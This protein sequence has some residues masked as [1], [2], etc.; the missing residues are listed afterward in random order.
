MFTIPVCLSWAR[1]L[2]GQSLQDL[3]PTHQSLDQ[4]LIKGMKT[5][6]KECIA[7]II[8]LYYT[9]SLEAPPVSKG[10]GGGGGG[11]SNAEVGNLHLKGRNALFQIYPL[12]YANK[13]GLLV[14]K[15]E[16][17]KIF[18]LMCIKTIL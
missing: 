15:E 3:Y 12:T 2:V 1:F 13:L 10:M 8:L 6:G 18:S 7:T 5:L 16:N 17:D 4:V 9:S 11:A 14:Y